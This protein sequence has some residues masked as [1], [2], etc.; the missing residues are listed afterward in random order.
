MIEI[1][2][3]YKGKQAD[4]SSGVYFTVVLDIGVRVSLSSVI[5]FLPV[6]SSAPL[7]FRCGFL[8]RRAACTSSSHEKL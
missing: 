2:Y 4:V 8:H 6:P 5:E 1:V 3:E 7:Y